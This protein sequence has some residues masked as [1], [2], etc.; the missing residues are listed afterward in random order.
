[1][2]VL[3]LKLGGSRKTVKIE[4]VY[5][6]TLEDGSERLY[7]DTIAEDGV[8]YKINEVFIKDHSGEIKVK[9]LWLNY[10]TDRQILYTSTL[11]KL[12]QYL[13]AASLADL[14]GK[15]I[16]IQPKENNFMAI[17]CYEEQ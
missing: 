14:V 13:K 17:V 8:K 4:N 5:T 6:K 11:G 9:G 1:M 7:F 3:N 12:L 15:E 2:D 16:L 10:D